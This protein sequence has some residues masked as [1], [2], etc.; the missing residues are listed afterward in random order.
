LEAELRNGNSVPIGPLEGGSF[1]LYSTEYMS[2]YF[3]EVHLGKRIH[4]GHRQYDEIPE[5]TCRPGPVHAEIHI[6]PEGHLDIYP[7]DPPLHASLTPIIV[8]SMQDCDVELVFLG[9]GYLKV[10][11]ELDAL[12]KG[13]SATQ[14]VYEP[15]MIEFS[16]I[17]ISDEEWK[18]QRQESYRP[19]P[20]PRD[21]FA[22]RLCGWD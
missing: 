19:P 10:R 14:R 7:F 12:L 8:E 11:I 13:P 6:Y 1:E 2:H 4:F 17:Y 5:M 18:R 15:K 9:H 22:S 21:S 16:G 3:V 20:S